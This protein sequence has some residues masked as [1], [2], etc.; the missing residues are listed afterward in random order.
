M[1][2][3]ADKAVGIL[4]PQVVEVFEPVIRELERRACAE[5]KPAQPEV[6]E[7]EQA[8]RIIVGLWSDQHPGLYTWNVALT[9]ALDRLRAAYCPDALAAYPAPVEGGQ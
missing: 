5:A 3:L 6:G 9:E 8:A 4:L 7:R 1:E 2:A